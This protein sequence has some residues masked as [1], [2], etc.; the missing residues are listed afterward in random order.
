MFDTERKPP[1]GS[2][3]VADEMLGSCNRIN[4]SHLPVGILDFGY[5]GLG[6]FGT[7]GILGLGILGWNISNHYNF[8]SL[9]LTSFY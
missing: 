3:E 4:S 2:T 1:T 9:Q 6:Y 7:L 8:N 5:F